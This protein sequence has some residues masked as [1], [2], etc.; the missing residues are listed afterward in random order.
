VTLTGST[1]KTLILTGNGKHWGVV[2]SR[3]PGTAANRLEA[4][5]TQS[6]ASAWTVGSY[7]NGHFNRTLI[8]HCG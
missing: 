1:S 3:N 4:I 8:E 2:P 7:N 5:Y 6:P